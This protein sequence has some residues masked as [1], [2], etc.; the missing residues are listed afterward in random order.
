MTKQF[1]SAQHQSPWTSANTTAVPPGKILSTSVLVF[2]G[3]GMLERSDGRFIRILGLKDGPGILSL[4]ELAGSIVDSGWISLAMA[5]APQDPVEQL[6]LEM[7]GNECCITYAAKGGVGVVQISVQWDIDT[8]TRF[9]CVSKVKSIGL[10][11]DEIDSSVFPFHVLATR[12]AQFYPHHVGWNNFEFCQADLSIGLYGLDGRRLYLV[13]DEKDTIGNIELFHCLKQAGFSIDDA[14]DVIESQGFFAAIVPHTISDHQLYVR[15][16]RLAVYPGGPEYF[17]C[18]FK[19]MGSS[20]TPERV[21]SF[22]PQFTEREAEI[23]SLL[24]QGLNLK[25]VARLVNRAQGTVTIQARSAMHKSRCR[26]IIS[27]VSTV[28]QMC[29]E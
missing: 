22:F 6:L 18:S 15:L 3:N 25:E 23:A 17:H 21:S 24:A 5:I 19:S 27:L 12:G 13:G 8:G 26:S 20:I 16:H 29:A 11:S 9:V 10:A 2:S 7:T 14:I 4:P 1:D 28:C